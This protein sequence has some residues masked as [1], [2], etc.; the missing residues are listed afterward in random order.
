M[1]RKLPD[2]ILRDCTAFIDGVS[3]VGQIGDVTVPGPS[4][5]VEELRNAGMGKVREVHLGYEKLEMSL[6]LPGLDPQ[7]W[8][9][10]GLKPGS[11]IQILVTGALVAEDGTSSAAALT[12]RGFFKSIGGGSWKPGA[13]GENDH[14]FAVNY[15]KLE[16]AGENVLEVDDYDVIV[17]GVS[18]R[19]DILQALLLN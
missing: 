5:K 1:T 18:Q 15:Y 14:N 13:I 9:L 8:K 19:A 7:V 3:K 17:G 16:I 12:V 6:K 4:L 2:Y 10:F 11:D